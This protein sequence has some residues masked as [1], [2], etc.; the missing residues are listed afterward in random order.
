MAIIRGVLIL[1]IILTNTGIMCSFIITKYDDQN[2]I[3][4]VVSSSENC[5]T[6]PTFCEI[7]TETS[8]ESY[9]FQECHNMG[10]NWYIW[11]MFGCCCC[12]NRQTNMA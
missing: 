8:L 2:E 12:Y 5:P 11:N 9:C 7:K 1:S 6:Y 3:E 4:K 10:Y